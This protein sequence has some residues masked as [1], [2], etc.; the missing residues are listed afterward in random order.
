[1]GSSAKIL[2][3]KLPY[4]PVIMYEQQIETNNDM[5]MVNFDKY[6]RPLQNQPP[7]QQK[8]VEVVYPDDMQNLMQINTELHQ[9]LEQTNN[10]REYRM[11]EWGKERQMYQEKVRSMEEMMME[12]GGGGAEGNSEAVIKLEQSEMKY[13]QIEDQLKQTETKMRMKAQQENELGKV[14]KHLE[15]KCMEE[16]YKNNQSQEE[17]KRLQQ[18]QSPQD[19]SGASVWG[20]K[21]LEEAN[22]HKATQDDLAQTEVLLAEQSQVANT[23]SEEKLKKLEERFINMKAKARAKIDEKNLE[24]QEL[25]K[26]TSG[27]SESIQSL[28]SNYQEAVLR[29]NEREQ[30]L[31]EQE[32]TLAKQNSLK[33]KYEYKINFLEEKAK[34]VSSVEVAEYEAKIK[35]LE[36]ELADS[37]L[38]TKTTKQYEVKIKSL[39]EK[40]KEAEQS[41]TKK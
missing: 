10:E 4:K 38:D 9:R 30:K 32:E 18:N 29:L 22:K 33:A 2:E 6:G 34:K 20:Q 15:E 3:Q 14:I 28:T 27:D 13:K 40:C 35:G 16:Q 26:K 1:M 19:A 41:A 17:I 31:Q 11:M 5:E 12:G 37:L 24:I 23:D 39:E 36:N 7:P 21:Y 25:T 8:K